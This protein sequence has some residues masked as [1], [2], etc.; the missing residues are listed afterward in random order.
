MANKEM[1]GARNC[2]IFNPARA[3]AVNVVSTKQSFTG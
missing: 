3:I 1:L 2:S